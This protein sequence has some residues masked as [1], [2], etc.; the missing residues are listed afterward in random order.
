MSLNFEENFCDSVI[1]ALI[2][3]NFNGMQDAIGLRTDKIK[4]E[5]AFS[6]INLFYNALPS[7]NVLLMS[8]TR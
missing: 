2:T 6:I 3:E 8:K 1:L 4:L 5:S 7:V